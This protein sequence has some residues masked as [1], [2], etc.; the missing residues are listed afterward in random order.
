MKVCYDISLFCLNLF[1]MLVSTNQLKYSYLL[2]NVI[3]FLIYNF[4]LSVQHTKCMDKHLLRRVEEEAVASKSEHNFLLILETFD[5]KWWCCITA[6]Q[7]MNTQAQLYVLRSSGISW[8]L[9]AL[10]VRYSQK[11][12][13]FFC[14]KLFWDSFNCYNFGTTGPI[15]FGVFSNTYLS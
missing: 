8:K 15:Q 1:R 14:F 11:K 5:S 3:H 13:H 6:D 7:P 10:I 12:M 2:H 9:G 4:W